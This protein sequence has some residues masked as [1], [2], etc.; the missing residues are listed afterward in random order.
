MLVND[1]ADYWWPVADLAAEVFDA[2]RPSRAQVES[3]RRAV[4][5]MSARGVLDIELQDQ[6]VGVQS[7]RVDRGD[8]L[9]YRPT[10]A[11]SRPMLCAHLPLS[12]EQKKR[13]AQSL[14]HT[15]DALIALD[16]RIPR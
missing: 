3:V 16:Q 6:T 13:R 4:K 1:P 11:A 14:A 8:F 12:V 7:A 5:S 15:L 2:V 9:A 10:H